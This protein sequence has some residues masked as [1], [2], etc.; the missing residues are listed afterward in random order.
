MFVNPAQFAVPM[1][2][3]AIA[4]GVVGAQVIGDDWTDPLL[5]AWALVVGTARNFAFC[6]IANAAA[7]FIARPARARAGRVAETSVLTG[8]AVLIVVTAFRDA[9]W[10][11]LAGG[12]VS[13]VAVL[14][15]LTLGA[16]LAAS[17]ITAV[18]LH[19]RPDGD[20]R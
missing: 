15:T 17:V 14:A 12:P 19:A 11:P 8:T 7:G 5:I 18:L 13:S 20:A 10:R 3:L 1:L 2:A 4:A 6:V 16:G 9:V